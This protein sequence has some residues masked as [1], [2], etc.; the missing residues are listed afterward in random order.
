MHVAKYSI[1]LNESLKEQA[2]SSF[3]NARMDSEKKQFVN[4]SIV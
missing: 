2:G 4:R 3:W 1:I